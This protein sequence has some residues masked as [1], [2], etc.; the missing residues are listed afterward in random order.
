MGLLIFIFLWRLVCASGASSRR[1]GGILGHLGR[2]LGASWRVLARLGRILARLGGVLGASWRVLGA[3]WN[4]W[5]PS[6]LQN[7]KKLEKPT[8]NHQ[9][10]PQD[11]PD[12]TWNGKRRLSLC[13][14]KEA[15]W[16]GFGSQSF[17]NVPERSARFAR[18]ARSLAALVHRGELPLIFL[19]FLMLYTIFDIVSIS[20]DLSWMFMPT[21]PHVS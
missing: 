8:K 3:S 10:S 6:S 9:T 15:F 12:S 4:V 14:L 21:W 7:R 18:C 19:V 5:P 16:N 17:P 11:K 2:V 20:I 13:F 1:L